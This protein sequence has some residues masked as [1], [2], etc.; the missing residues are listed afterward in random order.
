MLCAVMG[1]RL[2]LENGSL[3]ISPE[4]L[5]LSKTFVFFLRTSIEYLTRYGQGSVFNINFQ[6]SVVKTDPCLYLFEYSPDVLNSFRYF[7]YRQKVFY[8][9]R[10]RFKSPGYMDKDPFSKNKRIPIT[11]CHSWHR[12]TENGS[13]RNIAQLW[14]LISYD[15]IRILK[16][17]FRN[18]VTSSLSTHFIAFLFTGP[19]DLTKSQSLISRSKIDRNPKILP[20]CV[21]RKFLTLKAY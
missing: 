7:W 11:G 9:K 16:I 4:D 3:S 6:E 17:S 21:C 8:K 15:T 13:C 10:Y 14:K 2:F 12:F 20:C 5:I 18:C 1:I 19:F